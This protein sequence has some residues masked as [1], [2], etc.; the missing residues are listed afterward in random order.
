MFYIKLTGQQGIVLPAENNIRKIKPKQ[1]TIESVNAVLTHISTYA[2]V[3]SL[4]TVAMISKKVFQNIQHASHLQQKFPM[5]TSTHAQNSILY[6]N[7]IIE[8][9]KTLKL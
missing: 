9:Q 1:R 2:A 7:T 3:N 8:I 6:N 4:V 5:P